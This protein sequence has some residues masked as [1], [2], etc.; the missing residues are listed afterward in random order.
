MDAL[1]CYLRQ[2]DNNIG[3]T[4]KAFIEDNLKNLDYSHQ[5]DKTKIYSQG[6]VYNLLKIYNTLNLEYFKNKL[7][8]HITW[9]GKPIQ[10]G[11]SRVTF[12][13]YYDQIRLIKI[14]RLLDSP[15]FPDYFVSYVVYHEMLHHVCPSYFDAKGQHQIHSKEFKAREVE[16]EH[17]ELAQ[18]WIK[19]NHASFFI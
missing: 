18:T 15:S 4:V 11:S 12:G 17:Y 19:E 1:A 3:P 14:N 16:F 5:L 13:L 9:F 6:H 7:N 2:E 10:S 8:L